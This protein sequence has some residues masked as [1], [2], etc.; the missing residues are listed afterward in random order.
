[1]VNQEIQKYINFIKHAK[2]LSKKK[3]H[4]LCI[5]IKTSDNLEDIEKYKTELIESN[6]KLVIKCA[7]RLK[8]NFNN[9]NIDVMDLIA[10]GNIGLIKAVEEY[11]PFNKYGANFTSF[12]FPIINHQIIKAAKD[13]RLIKIPSTYFMY[14]NKIRELCRSK[15][16]NISE[17]QICEELDIQKDTFDRYKNNINTQY[18]SIDKPDDSEQ[19]IN[20]KELTIID[21]GGFDKILS[22]EFRNFMKKHLDK[23]PEKQRDILVELYMRGDK[24]TLE[25]VAG[26][27]GQSKQN[28]D[29]TKNRALEKL[30]KSLILDKSMGDYLDFKN[31]Y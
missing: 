2:P 11:D 16:E 8:N 29:S 15:G 13:F 20:I 1:V 10:E 12:A 7:S 26:R 6:L 3:Q 14:S 9:T 30:K 28:I 23:L 17:R 5:L 31:N 19:D 21:N 27:F 24:V 22:E 18:N 25:Q 4:E